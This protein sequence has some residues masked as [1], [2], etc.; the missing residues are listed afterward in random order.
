MKDTKFGYE[1]LALIVAL[2][3]GSTFIAQKTAMESIGPWSFTA[4][5]FSTAIIFLLVIALV[6]ERQHIKSSWRLC[7]IYGAP[8]GIILAVSSILQQVALLSSYA[9]KGGIIT[10]F[11]VCLIPFLAV[12]IGYRLKFREIL[13]AFTAIGGLYFLTVSSSF[14]IEKGDYLLIL[15]AFGWG[16]HILSLEV[17]LRKVKPIS[18]ALFQTSYCALIV[19]MFA[20]LVE[21]VSLSGIRGALLEL[22]YSG[23]VSAGLAFGL[24]ILC[25]QHLSPNRVGL[26]FS[27]ESLFALIFGWL[28]LG[29]VF[30][31]REIL[32]AGLM[33]I[34]LIIV[35]VKFIREKT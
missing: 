4:L 33:L 23:V 24:Q 2:I 6:L 7:L 32:G 27:T 31:Q 1:I 10:G 26:L 9:S 25:Q 12:F 3:W 28:L 19:S 20:P 15:S 29:E 21:N 14:S 35:R 13:A 22:F 16:F 17:C 8:P 34:S 30:T 11:Y 18:L 5:R